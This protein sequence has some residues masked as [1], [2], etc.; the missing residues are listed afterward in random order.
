MRVG[1]FVPCFVDQLFPRA[2]HATVAVLERHGVEVEFPTEQ[3]CCGQP[4][5]N[6][7]AWDEARPLA[8]RFLE[9]F[10]PY[11]H[12]IAP[13]AS[14]VAMVR[15]HYHDLLAER[16]PVAART[17]ELCEF[18]V[19]VL[20]VRRVDGAFPHRVA[21]HPGCHGLRELRLG[22]SSERVGA[23]GPRE[24][25][26]RVLL[27]SLDGVTLVDPERTDECCGFGGMFSTEEE[28][29][30]VRMGRDRLAD[31]A[32]AGAEVVT[33]TDPSCLMHLSGISRRADDGLRFHH[34]A[35]LL[36][37]GEFVTS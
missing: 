34:V 35:E 5:A 4:M 22:P 9:V 30:S 32:A 14:C 3:T 20:G 19:D 17:R 37:G 11:D 21:L 12:V 28:A 27:G 16:S 15:H 7:G 8:E 26:V 6:A 1:L 18:L 29:V 31:F 25:K 2:A 23:A 10:G 36:A 13:S 33:A 24:D